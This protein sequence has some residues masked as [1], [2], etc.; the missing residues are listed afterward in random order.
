[1]T[2]YREMNLQRRTARPFYL[3]LKSLGLNLVAYEDLKRPNGYHIEVLGLQ[4]L[5]TAHADRMRRRVAEHTPGLL[6][7]L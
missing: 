2:T 7:V 3:E 5:S 4:S 6:K 1:M